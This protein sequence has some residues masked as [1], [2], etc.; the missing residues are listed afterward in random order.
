M[1]Y[2]SLKCIKTMCANTWLSTPHID[3]QK[4]PQSEFALGVLCAW[5]G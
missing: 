1:Y 5:C 2:S 4:M 3:I